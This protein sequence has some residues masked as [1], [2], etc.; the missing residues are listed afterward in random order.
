MQNDIGL[1]HVAIPYMSRKPIVLHINTS[2]GNVQ[3]FIK[4]VSWII[5]SSQL[6]LCKNNVEDII[7]WFSIHFVATSCTIILYSMQQILPEVKH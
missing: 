7:I 3:D 5:Q 6:K 2:P 1:D 4:N